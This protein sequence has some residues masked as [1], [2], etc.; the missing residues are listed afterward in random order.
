VLETN[1]VIEKLIVDYLAMDIS[2]LCFDE[3]L[4]G[5]LFSDSPSGS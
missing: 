5:D 1:G 4:T 3:A 2:R